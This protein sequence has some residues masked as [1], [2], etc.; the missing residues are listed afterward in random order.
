MSLLLAC[1]A[2]L[3]LDASTHP[4]VVNPLQ[5]ATE[6][7]IA[8]ED[9]SSE[10]PCE[11]VNCEAWLSSM[12]CAELSSLID[13]IAGEI[14]EVDKDIETKQQLIDSY[15]AEYDESIAEFEECWANALTQEQID[16]CWVDLG[17]ALFF[18]DLI[19]SLKDEIDGLNELKDVLTE[20]LEKYQ[21]I[22]E[23]CCE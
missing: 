14:A 13:E 11:T 8:A 7:M 18:P 10:D 17:G 6:S 9:P 19:E 22:M 16:Q 4:R 3:T 12:S 15:Q 21:Q 23:C 20:E 2:L 5:P 1:L